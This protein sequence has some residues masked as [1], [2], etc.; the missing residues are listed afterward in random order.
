MNCSYLKKMLAEVPDHF[1]K[2]CLDLHCFKF[3]S[4]LSTEVHACNRV[5]L[6]I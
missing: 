3:P 4:M 1:S 6:T 5:E 2:A